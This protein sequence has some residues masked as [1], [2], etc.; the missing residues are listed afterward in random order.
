MRP[1][2]IMDSNQRI[3]SFLEIKQMKITQLDRSGKESILLKLP[4]F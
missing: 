4:I 3:K 1:E 2:N